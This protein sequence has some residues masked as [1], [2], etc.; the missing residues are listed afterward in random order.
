[1]ATNPSIFRFE[2]GKALALTL[3][4]THGGKAG[5]K[6]EYQSEK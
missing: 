1:V 5:K 6:V 2:I 3:L 4:P